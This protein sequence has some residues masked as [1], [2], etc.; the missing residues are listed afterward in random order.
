MA[1]RTRSEG[2]MG[3]GL[4]QISREMK[5]QSPVFI[6]GESRSGTSVLYRT[7]QKH[8][9]FAPKTIDLTETEV[10]ALLHRVF[11]FHARYPEQLLKFMLRDRDRWTGFLRSIRPCRVM[12]GILL[13]INLLI[14]R[15]PPWLWYANLHH[16]TLRSFLWHARAAR[17]CPRLVE[18][19][20]TNTPHLQHLKRTFPHG[21]FL[22]VHRHPV[23]VFAS[24]RRRAQ[25]DPGAKWADIGVEDFCERYERSTSAVLSWVDAGA[26]DLLMV[27]YESFTSDPET[28]FRE[29]CGFLDERFEQE[30]LIERDPDSRRWRGD[31]LLWGPIVTTPGLWRDHVSQIEVNSIERRLARLMSRLGYAPYA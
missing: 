30:A 31:P 21:R 12:N 3:P 14:R 27:S 29:I 6:V 15:P 8:T 1:R 13:P 26:D 9:S 25:N 18:K 11:M 28:S 5:N 17:R 20:P 23:D 16:L 22:Y 24:Y 7:L 10:F 2:M 19:T 4:I